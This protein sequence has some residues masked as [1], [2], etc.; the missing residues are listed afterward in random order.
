MTQANQTSESAI[1]ALFRAAADAWRIPDLRFRILFTLGILVIFRFF[2]HVPV[3]GVDREALAAAFEANPLL[4]FLDLFSGGA[5]RNLSIAAL[6]VYPYITASIILQIL[7]PIIPS[8]KNL[9]QEG[10]GGRQAIN[11]YTH[12][13][14]VP[15]AF[16]QGYGQLNLFAGAFTS[17]G[18]AAISGIG[19]GA[20]TLNTVAI[21][22]AMTAGTMLLV[23]MGELVTEKGIGNG[24][25]LIIFAGIVSTL[26]QVV[27]QL[28][29]LRDQM[30][31]VGM[32]I[33]IALAIIYLIVY[34][35]EAQRRIPV[36]YGRSVFRGGQMYR[37]SGA[38]HI[39]LR[40]NAAGM[41]PLIFAFSI[42]ILPSV[43]A[44]YFND[45]SGGF[46][47]TIASF[48]QN[49]F[50][51]TSTI[52]WI[53]VFLLV[54]VFTFFYTLVVHN[55]QNL[56]ENLQKNGGF[57]P[58]IRPGPPT[59]IY[60]MRVVLRITWGGALFLGF[61]AIMPF[62]AQL[63]TN[64]PNATTIIQSTSLLIMVGVALDTMRQLESQLLMRNYEGFVR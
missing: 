49:S 35:A 38:T 17:Q 28:W 57:V 14:T 34:F 41:I 37:Q 3:P 10:E 54:V 55:Q 47:S 1:P 45:G 25:S 8:L 22:T 42:L 6:G 36:Q 52:Y 9:S 30:F 63:V 12:Y 24:I 13:L 43:V 27:G 26:P 59:K 31:Q 51:P 64:L 16:L 19:F 50:G 32:L 4:G 7:T 39:P 56:A 46:V 61:I 11:R 60:L 29:L 33:F 48:F 2:A 58:G 21:L 23:W 40:V 15:L 44:S 62:L 5:L 20:N 18:G 53:A